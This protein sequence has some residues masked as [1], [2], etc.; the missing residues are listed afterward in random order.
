MLQTQVW[1]EHPPHPG[2]E[3][4]LAFAEHPLLVLHALHSLV[5]AESH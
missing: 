4:P 1:Q 5:H 3:E 2:Q